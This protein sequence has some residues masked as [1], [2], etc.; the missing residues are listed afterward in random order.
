MRGR[1][2]ADEIVRH[3]GLSPFLARVLAGRGVASEAVERHLNPTFDLLPDPNV[4]TAMPEAAARLADACARGEKVAIFGDYDVDGATSSALL[5]EFLT[6]AGCDVQVHI[7]DRIFEGYGPN[8]AAIDG[9]ADA[10]ATLLITADCGAT[11][12]EPLAHARA[13]GL[14]VVVIDHHQMGAELPPANALV[15]PNRQDDLSGLGH[16]AACGVAFLTLIATRQELR[17]RGVTTAPNLKRALD[18]V[19]LGTVADVVPLTG[20]NRL[21]VREGLEVL[22]RRRRPGLRALMDAARL[23]GPPTPYH[24]GF[25]LGPRINAGGRIG[26]AG[27]GCRLMLTGDEPEAGRIAAELDRLNGERQAIERATLAEAEAEAYAALGLDGE[28]AS[29][30]VVSGEGWHPGV[31]GL[32]AARLKERFRRPAFAVAFQPDGTGT[33][34]GRSIPGV[35]LGAAVRGAVAE[36]LLAK[37]GGHAMAAGV[38]VRKEALGAFRAYLEEALGAAVARARADQSLKIDAALTAAAATLDLARDLERAGPFGSGAPEPVL[39]LAAHTLSSADVVGQGHLRLRLRAGDGASV[40][41]VAFRA[42]DSDLGRGLIASRG[43]RVHVA[44]SLGVDRWGGQERVSLR[45]IDAAPA[46]A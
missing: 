18:L 22:R 24:L 26:D 27:L 19:A 25:L 5:A 3:H 40:S 12:F 43:A 10:G 37:G 4:L 20:I 42:A 30:A 28:G 17:R 33:G 21:F 13:R 44:G 11:S 23:D 29:V 6:S 34:S 45:V 35:D 46:E 9:L 1:A 15:N 8:V 36:G 7:P 2:V 16:L 14:D 39:A 41:G 32:V 38:T 31:V